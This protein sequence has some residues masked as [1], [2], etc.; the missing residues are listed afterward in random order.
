MKP[1]TECPDCGAIWGFDEIQ[2]GEC[3][4]C[5]YPNNDLGE[6]GDDWDDEEWDYEDDDDEGITVD[7]ELVLEFITNYSPKQ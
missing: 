6:W 5:G 7:K 3:G 4:A 1:K 2:F